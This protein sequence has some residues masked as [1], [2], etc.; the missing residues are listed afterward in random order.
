MSKLSEH[1]DVQR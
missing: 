1:K